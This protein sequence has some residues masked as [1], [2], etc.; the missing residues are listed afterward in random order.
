MQLKLFV[1]ANLIAIG[2]WTTSVPIHDQSD[3]MSPMV[4]PPGL[5]GQDLQRLALSPT[6]QRF[7]RNFP[8]TI[9]RY[10]DGQ[11]EVIVRWVRSA[12][13]QLH[14]AADCFRG[15]GYAV[16][17]ARLTIDAEQQTWRCF[18][19]RRGIRSK[20]ICERIQDPFGRAWTDTSAWYW[21][22][23]LGRSSGPWWAITIATDT[24]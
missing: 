10:G 4:L 18:Q 5:Q 21:D 19:A 20:Q 1:V 22:A 8:G 12:T 2:T 14:P 17:S 6:E 9:A 24:S 23:I 11:R 3:L 16:E 7:S 13:R 15:L